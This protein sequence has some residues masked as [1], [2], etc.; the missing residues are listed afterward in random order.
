MRGVAVPLI[1]ADTKL[2]PAW[3]L[4]RLG[5]RLR[6]RQKDLAAYRMYYR[7]EQLL[8]QVPVEDRRAWLEFQRK[9]RTNMCKM[10]VRATVARQLNIGVTD[11]KGEEDTRAWS[12]LQRNRWDSKQKMLFRSVQS[13][14]RGFLM[15][16]E[17]PR[18]KRR[19]L[20]TVEH[21]TEVITELD[22]A[23]G[24]VRAAL[25]V[26]F[27][28]ID[29]V[30]RASLYLAPE[31]ANGKATN[32]RFKTDTWSATRTM[33]WGSSNW[34]EDGDARET[35]FDRPPIVPF[36]YIPDLGEE[37]EPDFWEVRDIQDRFNLQVLNRMF[38][39][40]LMAQPQAF[41]TGAKVKKSVDPITGMEIAENPFPRG[42]AGVWVNEN[43]KGGFGQLQPADLTNLIRGHEFEIRTLFV[44][45]STPAYYMPGDL[46]N[47]STD[48]VMAL[49]A[50]HV[51]KVRELN[52]D[53]G[54]GIEEALGLA[55]MVAGVD[56]DFSQHEVRW[57]DPRHLNPAV[58]ADMG[59]KKR[60]MGWPLPMVAE[61]MGESPQRVS[62]LRAEAATE[63]MQNALAPTFQAPGQQPATVPAGE[64]VPAVPADLVG[65]A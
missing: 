19:P 35:V 8:P 31:G 24:D 4:L 55:A 14:G 34:T 60:S 13:T 45:T 17:H 11:A 23:T 1:D 5:R 46:V 52:T 61:D 10:V 22:P 29:E 20:I 53:G 26:W 3:W 27:D 37:P 50:N 58:L 47:V 59:V 36:E 32:H 42:G 63:A 21:P 38:V 51:E 56:P 15:I 25:K 48:T 65:L 6:A 44:L 40:R 12:W 43:D 62:R 54:E 18:T 64:L 39:E 16:G 2:S 9:A 49:D 33:A 41:A 30:G 7:G 57:A 28:D